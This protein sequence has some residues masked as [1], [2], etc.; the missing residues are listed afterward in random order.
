M[1][2]KVPEYGPQKV[3]RTT[4]SPGSV[5]QQSNPS[6]A[7]FGAGQSAASPAS[8]G[9]APR[10]GGVV[11]QAAAGVGNVFL[12]IAEKAR[13]VRAEENLLEYQRARNDVLMNPDT[14]YYNKKG[15]DAYDGREATT[16]QLQKLR[17]ERADSIQDPIAREMFTKATDS[18]LVQDEQQTMEFAARNFDAWQKSVSQ[19]R[20][21]MSFVDA[22]RDWNNPE[23]LAIDFELG[24]QAI[25]DMSSGMG[26]EW[27]T[28]EIDQY[29]GR[30]Y[31]GVVESAVNT[32]VQDGENLLEK[33]DGYLDPNDEFQLKEKLRVKKEN[34]EQQEV[35]TLAI[36]KAQNL[37]GD[38]W[39]RPDARSVILDEIAK[40][41][42]PVL[43]DRTMAE[44]MNGLNARQNAQSEQQ[45]AYYEQ[46]V[47]LMAAQGWTTT[48]II[49]QNPDA[50]NKMTGVQQAALLQAEQQ[51][52]VKTDLNLWTGLTTSS[53]QELASITNEEL[54]EMQTMLSTSDYQQLV[55]RIADV[56]GGGNETRIG[57]T[58]NAQATAAMKEIFGNS[59]GDVDLQE[60]RV[61]YGTLQAE[62]NARKA[63]LGRELSYDETDTLY[64]DLTSKYLVERNFLGIPMGSTEYGLEDV[65]INAV[66]EITELLR[67]EGLTVDSPAIVQFYLDNKDKF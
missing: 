53:D 25:V 50:W 34:Q 1:T 52:P 32:S 18:L 56:R 22:A 16:E 17:R 19:Q 46:A 29:A 6:A 5:I 11:G 38:Y 4:S 58:R 33:F 27:T 49:A 60:Q 64:S 10:N 26:A 61:F 51:G 45:R 65:P 24:K 2:I 23:Q 54:T 48:Q 15:R 8:F 31:R 63:E 62:Y 21:E 36:V 39:E 67:S 41:D 14:G 3:A 40:I 57:W 35:A 12:Q 55:K 9:V 20:V 7:T 13:I 44:A 37:V 59:Q 42:D 30:F 66:Q 47:G 43:R 28:N